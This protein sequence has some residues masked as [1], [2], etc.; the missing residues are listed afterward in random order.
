MWRNSV[1]IPD[2]ADQ[3]SGMMSI[4][5]PGWSRSGFRGESD[6]RSGAKPINDRA[7][8]E[9]WSACRNTRFPSM[10]RWC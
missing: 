8:P 9:E 5:I 3:R 7:W 10:R 4:T 2:Q 6:R 1:R